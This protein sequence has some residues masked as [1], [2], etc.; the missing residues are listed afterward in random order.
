MLVVG[1]VTDSQPQQA[2]AD[3][4]VATNGDDAW[5][6]RLPDLNAAGTDGPFATLARARDAIRQLKATEGLEGPVTV[7]VRGGAYYLATPVIFGPEDS[8]TEDCP[9]TY[10]AYPGEKPV[11]SGGKEITGWQ[12]GEGQLW[13]AEVPEVKAGQWYFRQLFVNGE[14]R[15]R[16]RLPQ[17]GYYEVVEAAEPERRAFRYNPGDIDPSWHNLEDVELVSLQFWTEGRFPITQIDEETHTV[18]LAGETWRPITWCKGYY[19]DNVYE[20]LAEPGDWYLDRHTGVLYYWPLPGEDMTRAEVIAPTTEQLVCFQ[21]DVEAQELVHHVT[22]CGLTFYYST[23]LLPTDGFNLMQAEVPAQPGGM[24]CGPDIPFGADIPQAHGPVPFAVRAEGA[25]HLSLE[26]NEIAHTGAWGIELSRGCQDNRI[27]GN[28]MHDLGAG[29]IRVGETQKP[30]KE[31]EKACRTEISDNHIHDGCTVY[32]GA[33]GIWIGQGNHNR[34]AHN[35]IHGAFEWA[36]SVGWDWDFTPNPARDNIIEYNHIHHLGESELGTHGVIYMLGISPGTVIRHNLIHHITGGG[37]GIVLDA[38]C[39]GILVENNICHHTERGFH[40]NYGCAGNLIHNNIFALTADAQTVRYGDAPPPGTINT[41]LSYQNIYYWK[42]G[43]LFYDKHDWPDFN[44]MRDYN[45]YF[46]AS[47]Q[48][49]KFINYTFEEWKQKGLDVHSAIADPLFA[50]PENG[51][52]TLPPESPAFE[53][54]FK[55]IDLSNIGPRPQNQRF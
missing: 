27:V 13:V 45:L 21:G 26:D 46:D 52:F 42:Q 8:G 17:Q 34:I 48:P 20:G 33:P 22:L 19:I 38:G 15:Y 54:G 18:T 51:D 28:H 53:L 44:T 31:I 43:R 25:H 2:E 11:L 30:E 32:L 35:E 55:P 10:M 50:D 6:G 14:R 3:F 47:G 5:S 7:M 12:R 29:A 9:I 1:T 4:Y 23:W 37:F 36:I 41:N 40:F 49:V 39:A 16:A 24:T